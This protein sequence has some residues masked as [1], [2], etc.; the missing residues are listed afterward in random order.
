MARALIFLAALFASRTTDALQVDVQGGEPKPEAAGSTARVA[1][2]SQPQ[3]RQEQRTVVAVDSSGQESSF[4]NAAGGL[5]APYIVLAYGLLG[6]FAGGVLGP[7]VPANVLPY[8]VCGIY[9]CFSMAI[10]I[11][12]AVQKKSGSAHGGGGGGGG[13]AFNPACAVLVTEAVKFCLSA[14][15]YVTAAKSD[16]RA[17]VP[18]QLTFTDAKW[19]AVPAVMFTAN[20]VL[21]Y[22]A[23]GKNDL[24]AFSVFRDTVILWTAAIW[25]CVFNVELGWTRM[26]GIGVVFLGLVV[27]KVFSTRSSGEFSWMFLWVMLLTSCT[28]AGCVANE[29]ALKK[30]RDLDINVQNMVLYGFCVVCAFVLLAATDPGRVTGTFFAG[31]DRHTWVTIGLQSVA[32]MLVSRLLKH[33]DSVMKTMAACLRVPLIV[34][35]APAF[36]HVRSSAASCLSAVIVASGCFVYLTQGLL[37]A[38]PSKK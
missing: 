23:I 24:S 14:C 11:S 31:F 18:P 5:V 25:R 26:C 12:I 8:L 1:G 2:S 20:N 33:A 16:G 28:A 35:I 6:L 10:D 3:W 29:F 27:N 38:A 30:N 15:I 4:E 7:R 37:P 13:Y 17:G 36:T 19:L 32:G 21:V 22:V 34:M 9:M